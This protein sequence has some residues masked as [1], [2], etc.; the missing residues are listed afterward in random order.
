MRS[1][2]IKA[3]T[4]L[5]IFAAVWVVL[6]HFRPCWPQAPP[7][8]QR[9][10]RARTQQRRPGRRPVLHPQRVRADLELPRPDGTVVVDARHPAL[11]VAAAGQGV[12]GLPGHAA[13]GRA[14]DHLHAQR[15]P[16]AVRGSST[17]STRSATSASFSW[18]SCGS[19]RSSTASSWDGPAWSI[20]A[21]W[22]AYL[23]FGV[24]V[25]VIFRMARATR[26]RSL[27]LAGDR[28]HRCRR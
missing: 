26:A 23:M 2:E 25:L 19:S 18:C 10:A 22:L 27:M 21:E 3:L 8:L 14:V 28:G 9:R 11:P 5:R 24:L 4:G 1:G 12:A 13:P 20:S 16:R 7:G 6:F 15:R 17:R